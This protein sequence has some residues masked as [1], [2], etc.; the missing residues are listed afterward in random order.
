MKSD[1]QKLFE[2]FEKVCG[3][4]LLKE[5]KEPIESLKDFLIDNIDLEPYNNLDY[6]NQN[7]QGD[8]KIIE[9]FKIFKEEKEYN[10]KRIGLSN[11]LEDWFRGIPTVVSSLPIYSDELNNFLYA[12]G[13]IDSQD[14]DDEVVDKIFYTELVKII[15]N[16]VK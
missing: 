11:A 7:A 2:A 4:K 8:D 9:M 13:Y 3:V 15:L 12:I 14:V 10:I 16:V 1:K 6:V 5:E